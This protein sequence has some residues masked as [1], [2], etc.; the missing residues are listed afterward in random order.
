[1]SAAPPQWLPPNWPD[2]LNLEWKKR[3]EQ[4][5]WS[6]VSAS[7]LLTTWHTYCLTHGAAHTLKP[8]C[9]SPHTSG[10]FLILITHLFSTITYPSPFSCSHSFYRMLRGSRIERLY[11]EGCGILANLCP[12]PLVTTFISLTPQSFPCQEYM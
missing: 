2:S 7:V 10:S 1:M 3:E 11:L 4:L 5:F 12:A 8:S 6:S 9:I